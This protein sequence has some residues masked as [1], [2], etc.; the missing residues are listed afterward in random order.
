MK[1]SSCSKGLDLRKQRKETS[2]SLTRMDPKT[3]EASASAVTSFC[4]LYASPLQDANIALGQL[5]VEDEVRVIEDAL[6]G[7]LS[8]E[9]DVATV[10]SIRKSFNQPNTW[11]HLSLHSLKSVQSQI[12]LLES[13]GGGGHADKLHAADLPSLLQTEKNNTGPE[14]VF[15]SACESKEFGSIF[16]QAGAKH[17]I[18]C[19]SRLL[20]SSARRF[21]GMLYHEL[22]SQKQIH[23]AFE[24]ASRNMG[25]IGD[26]TKYVFLSSGSQ[27]R[28]LSWQNICPWPRI[29]LST[30]GLPPPVEGFVGRRAVIDAVLRALQTCRCVVLH[31]DAPLGLSATLVQIANRASL[32]GRLFPG[33]VACFPRRMPGGLWVV[34]DADSLLAGN[35]HLQIRRHL[36]IQGS[37]ILL[38]CRRAQHDLFQGAFKTINIELP[39]LSNGDLAELFLKRCHRRLCVADFKEECE[40]A[41]GEDPERRLGHHEV[42]LQL[43]QGMGIFLGRPGLACEAAAAVFDGSARVRGNFASLIRKRHA[44]TELTS[45]DV[46]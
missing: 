21:A 5:R 43:R 34:D 39:A 15:V 37:A 13:E 19:S 23:T 20:D 44:A 35:G 1:S 38:A 18:C 25:L 9:V 30:L 33:R 4:F 16:L 42:F 11:L 10:G 7:A 29:R 14:L 17:V 41:D 8:F 22:A 2:E 6:Q 28:K 46:F 26:N 27:W 24:V 36:E 31:C 3:D 12:L 40:L 45:A 32:P